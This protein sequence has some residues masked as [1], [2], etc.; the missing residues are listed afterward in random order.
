MRINT[1]YKKRK[2]RDIQHALGVRGS[3]VRG[4]IFILLFN[5]LCTQVG[6][7][8]NHSLKKKKKTK[9]DGHRKKL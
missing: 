8:M 1:E 2:I 4:F 6:V 5:D 9:R 3:K 7:P